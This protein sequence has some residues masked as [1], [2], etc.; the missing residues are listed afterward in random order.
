[1]LN[2]LALLLIAYAPPT[3]HGQQQNQIESFTVSN[4]QCAVYENAGG[5]WNKLPE[6]PLS[7]GTQ[8]KAR[9][10]QG[11]PQFKHVWDGKRFL[12]T[13]TQC[14]GG[15]GAIP[16]QAPTSRGTVDTRSTRAALKRYGFFVRAGVISY[17]D[18]LGIV[19]SDATSD[20]LFPSQFGGYLALGT[21]FRM[22]RKFLFETSLGGFFATSKITPNSSGTIIYETSNSA[23]MGGLLRPWFLWFPGSDSFAVCFGPTLIYR[24]GNWPDAPGTP[25]SYSFPEKSA[26]LFG[27]ELELRYVLDNWSFGAGAGFLSPANKPIFGGGIT[28]KF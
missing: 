20:T 12:L 16:A 2:P 27:G 25:V 14:L 8:V 5:K 15:G 4:T 11:R 7:V 28:R 17:Q 18:K 21:Q 6:L 22:N 13:S 1:M 19:G 26:L 3:A 10:V 9:P 24:S 23:A